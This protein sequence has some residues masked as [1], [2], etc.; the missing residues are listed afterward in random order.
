MGFGKQSTDVTEFTFQ[1]YY[2]RDC[3]VWKAFMKLTNCQKKKPQH[4]Q[5][6][7]L[8]NK[9]YKPPKHFLGFQGQMAWKHITVTYSHSFPDFCHLFSDICHSFSNAYHSYSESCH[10]YSDTCH[11]YS[12]TSH[13]WQISKVTGR[14]TVVKHQIISFIYVLLGSNAADDMEY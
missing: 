3:L 9:S 5:A 2:S 12:D 8:H 7:S 14:L 10:S 1:T 11:S 13:C 4:L 6:Y